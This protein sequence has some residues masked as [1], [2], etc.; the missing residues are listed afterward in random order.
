MPSDVRAEPVS[1]GIVT[2][3]KNR[4]VL[5]RRAL[6]S[7]KNQTFDNWSLVVVNDGGEPGSVDT[8]VAAIFGPQETR[9]RVLHHDQSK[10]ME[11]ASNAGLA[12]LDT[13]YAII[14]D[15]DD[16]WAPGFLAVMTAVVTA[17]RAQ[18]PSI[19]GIACRLN[20]VFENVTANHVHIERVEPWHA[21]ANDQINEGFISIQKMLVRNQFPPIAFMFD[22]AT[23]KEL[24]M[25]DASLPVLGDRDFHT[26]FVLKHDIWAHPEFLAF[27]HHRV[28]ATGAMGNSIHAGLDV[29]RMYNAILRNRW[30]REAMRN[31]PENRILL[32]LISE[33]QDTPPPSPPDTPPPSPPPEPPDYRSMIEETIRTIEQT[34]RQA[35][36][37][38]R[39][40]VRRLL[41]DLVRK[42]KGRDR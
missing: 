17:K 22:L 32:S 30:F 11:A 4:T 7:V 6:E 19:K 40:L 5:L 26:R 10:G 35:T 38:N 41:S 15:D 25:F 3:T 16:S 34:I 37:A 31:S 33:L 36:K 29:H 20:A 21:S 27:Y 42:I 8:L 18:F 24:G 12:T 39:P 23:C 14:H 13:T 2:R 1:V 9:V 28:T